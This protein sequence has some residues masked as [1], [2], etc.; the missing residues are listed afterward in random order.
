MKMSYYLMVFLLPFP[1]R[2]AQVKEKTMK[3]WH[4]FEG[5]YEEWI[6]GLVDERLDLNQGVFEYPLSEREEI[7]HHVQGLPAS[8]YKGGDG[9]ERYAVELVLRRFGLDRVNQ[10]VEE[11]YIKYR[12]WADRYG[13]ERGVPLGIIAGNVWKTHRDSFYYGSTYYGST[14][15]IG[16]CMGIKPHMHV[17]GN[18]CEVSYK[19][20]GPHAV[21]DLATM[22]GARRVLMEKYGLPL[23]EAN[24]RK[25][26]H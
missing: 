26:R 12:E 10:K 14:C 13:E 16:F 22:E 17:L 24:G 6:K 8:V 11:A 18:T 2:K 21:L 9:N 4:C 5:T 3:A 7:R 1:K 25:E 23:G 19:S 15:R 20:S